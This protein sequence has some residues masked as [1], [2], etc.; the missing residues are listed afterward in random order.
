MHKISREI[1]NWIFTIKEIVGIWIEFIKEKRKENIVKYP[2]IKANGKKF[3]YSDNGLQ[4]PYCLYMQPIDRTVQNS[5]KH[6]DGSLY[7]FYLKEE[8]HTDDCPQK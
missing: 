5:L 8:E 3:I 7:A 4:C 6:P 1:Q 2:I